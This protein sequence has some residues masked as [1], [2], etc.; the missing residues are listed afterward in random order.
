MKV[1]KKKLK[2]MKELEKFVTVRKCLSEEI[3]LQYVDMYAENNTYD[4]FVNSVK[5]S[6]SDKSKIKDSLIQKIIELSNINTE[7]LE[8]FSLVEILKNYDGLMLKRKVLAKF[9]G[10][11][12]YI[13]VNGRIGLGNTVLISKENYDKLNLS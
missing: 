2:N 13:A 4:V 3:D 12:N 9:L 10:A 7:M 1:N 8:K 5:I 11:S 6:Q